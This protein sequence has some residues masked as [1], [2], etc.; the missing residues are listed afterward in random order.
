MFILKRILLVKS[1]I[2][3]PEEYF[4]CHLIIL[5]TA[6]LKA[7]LLFNNLRIF[8][9][10]CQLLNQYSMWWTWIPTESYIF[11]PRLCRSHVSRETD[12]QKLKLGFAAFKQT[13]LEKFARL[14]GT[15]TQQFSSLVGKIRWNGIPSGLAFR[16]IISQTSAMYFFTIFCQLISKKLPIVKCILSSVHWISLLMNEIFS[17]FLRG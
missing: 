1:F 5:Y 12:S 13:S 15:S 2:R 11:E 3:T 10:L 14:V 8:S 7:V 4:T 9:R 16:F 17:M 6:S